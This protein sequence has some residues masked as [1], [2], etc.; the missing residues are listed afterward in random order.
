[1]SERP[2]GAILAAGLGTRMRP[3]T[4]VLPKPLLPFLNTPIIAYSIDHLYRAGVRRI[5]VNLHHLGEAIPPVVERIAAIY[6]DPVELVFVEE[7]TAR[8]TAGGIAGIWRALGRPRT[9]LVCLNG[10]SVMD[11]DLASELRHHR[12]EGA[13][14]TM[15]TRPAR[16]G[17]PGGV[18]SDSRGN[19]V[20]L[21]D[22]RLKAGGRELDFM[23]VHLLEPETL[24]HVDAVGDKPGTP[25]MVG[26]VYM[27]WMERGIQPRASVV[28]AFWVA[29][30]TPQLLLDSTQLCLAEPVVFPQ[31]PAPT[32]ITIVSPSQVNDAALVK[33]PVFLGAYA[34]VGHGARLGPGVCVDGTSIGPNTTVSDALLYGMDRVEGT[35]TGCVAISGKVVQVR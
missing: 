16:G 10:D 21:R 32:P 25:C 3:F 9:T 1:M 5:G 34:S 14:A 35:W 29:L 7:T 15:L 28:D 17:H 20:R 31:S 19:V 22:L 6:P 26:D 33:P 2:V 27:P 24:V 23:G 12:A 11:V 30:D 8:G 18:A 13:A 4:E